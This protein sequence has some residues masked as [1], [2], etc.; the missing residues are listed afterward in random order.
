MRQ[1]NNLP[2]G[3]YE[4]IE[5]PYGRYTVVIVKKLDSSITR[6]FFFKRFMGCHYR[7]GT[8]LQ[9]DGKGGTSVLR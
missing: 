8:I 3:K 5:V 6:S 7:I 2:E 4:V 1:K 9:S